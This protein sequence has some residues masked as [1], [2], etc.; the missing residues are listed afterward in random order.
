MRL[1]RLAV[2]Q[3]GKGVGR[4][5]LNAT[6][7][8]AQRLAQTVGCVGLVVD[9]KPDAVTFYEGFG[10]VQLDADAG[11]L[12]DRPEP[13]PMFLELASVPIGGY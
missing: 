9:A 13:V 5:L 6:L 4:Q 3:Q 10:F 12:G 11:Q 2:D 1:A 8:L 7:A